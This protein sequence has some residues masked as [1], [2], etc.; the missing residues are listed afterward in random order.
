MRES[1][2]K[3]KKRYEINKLVSELRD[4]L[5]SKNVRINIENYFNLIYFIKYLCTSYALIILFVF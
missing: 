3:K 5:F 4:F 1:K 2:L